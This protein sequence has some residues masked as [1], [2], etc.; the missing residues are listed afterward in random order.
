MLTS[1][2]NI[3]MFDNSSKPYFELNSFEFIWHGQKQK[4]HPYVHSQINITTSSTLKSD[5]L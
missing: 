3:I 4:R 2:H 5:D 1:V